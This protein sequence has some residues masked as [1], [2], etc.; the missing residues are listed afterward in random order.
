VLEG[1]RKASAAGAIGRG[2]VG[3][4]G[5]GV[6]IH[7]HTATTAPRTSSLG[8]VAS[9]AITSVGGNPQYRKTKPSRPSRQSVDIRS[10]DFRSPPQ[11]TERP[12][13]GRERVG[14]FRRCLSTAAKWYADRS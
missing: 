12:P 9:P 3:L 2:V 7:T 1:F 4:A 14:S 8:I 13:S 11:A 10:G 6:A 5:V